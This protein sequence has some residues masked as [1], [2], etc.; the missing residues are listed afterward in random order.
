MLLSGGGQYGGVCGVSTTHMHGALA[1][2]DFMHTKS[3]DLSGKL[4]Q[5]S[6]GQKLSEHTSKKTVCLLLQKIAYP[7]LLTHDSFGADRCCEPT[8]FTH[9]NT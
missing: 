5:L 2:N 3:T 8:Q 4:F 1:E 9:L 7:I 6:S